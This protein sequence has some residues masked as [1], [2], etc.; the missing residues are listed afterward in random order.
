MSQNPLMHLGSQFSKTPGLKPPLAAA[1]AS[2]EVQLDRELARYRRTRTGGYRASSQ[3]S[4]DKNSSVIGLQYLTPVADTIPFDTAIPSLDENISETPISETNVT[5]VTYIN[6]ITTTP[7]PPPPPPPSPRVAVTPDSIPDPIKET[8]PSPLS[9]SASIVPVTTIKASTDENV[10]SSTHQNQPDNYLESS[11]ALLR[12]LTEEAPKPQKRPKSNS[13]SLLSPLGIGSILLFLM[14]SII[15]GAV[16]LN[17]K[18][19]PQFSLGGL[20]KRDGSTATNSDVGSSS[21]DGKTKTVAQPQ[22]TPITR[23][24]NLASYEFPEVK[25]PNDVVGLTPKPKPTPTVAPPTP[26]NVAPPVV[27][28]ISAPTTQAPVAITPSPTPTPTPTDISISEIKPSSDGFYH[29][30]IDNTT[31]GAFANA[32]K[33]VPDAYLSPDGKLIY[34]GAIKNKEKV[35]ELLND[36]RQKGLNARVK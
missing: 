9:S 12:S 32:R 4:K 28:A 10:E 17:P 25:S 14:A 8:A 15:L 1:L 5:P 30:V 29:V 24:P 3:S 11:E 21:S 22:L 26:Q 18:L 33:V 2:L 19:L 31:E 16:V 34:L 27:P 35:Q 36:V 6:E 23:Y 20:F 7:P 13:D